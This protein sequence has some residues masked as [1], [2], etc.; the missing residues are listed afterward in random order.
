MFDVKPITDLSLITLPTLEKHT[1]I[2]RNRHKRAIRQLFRGKIFN[3]FFLKKLVRACYLRTYLFHILNSLRLRYFSNS[4]W[5]SARPPVFKATW[6]KFVLDK[7]VSGWKPN[8]SELA[9]RG[10]E[11][12]LLKSFHWLTKQDEVF[13]G[14]P[15]AEWVPWHNF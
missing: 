15:L 1:D 8:G 13:S 11:K 5:I 10:I 12:C 14:S 7:G 2:R 4:C 9:V 6:N 3:V